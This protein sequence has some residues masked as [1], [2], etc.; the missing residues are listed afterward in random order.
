M[1][2]LLLLSY[3]ILAFIC[4]H[5]LIAQD[6][7]SSEHIRSLSKGQV[8][9]QLFNVL[10]VNHGVE[11]YKLTYTTPDIHGVQDTASGLL[12]L[13]N[14][15]GQFPL[16][17]NQHG[18]VGNKAQVP[19]NENGGHLLAVVT[20]AMSYVTVMPDY[21]GLGDAR[22]F[23]P[24]L[25]AKTEASASID[26]MRATK[27]FLE[28]MED[29][30]I[31]EQVFITGYSQGGHAALALH[32]EL[33]LHHS[34]E[35]VVTA[36]A[37]MSGPYDMSGTMIDFGFAE[38]EYFFPGYFPYTILSYQL[39][40]GNLFNEFEDYFKQPYATEIERF[41]THQIDLSE[42]NEFCIDQLIME[43]GASIPIRML[44]DSVLENFQNHSGHP[45]RVAFKDNDLHDWAPASPTRLYYCQADD[46]VPFF[47]SVAAD[48]IMNVNGASDLEA[49]DVGSN[50]DHGQCVLPAMNSTLFFFSNFQDFMTNT[51]EYFNENAPI[52][53]FPNPTSDKVVI[54]YPSEKSET[55]N[56][57]I[58]NANGQKVIQTQILSGET[59]A[60][61]VQ[62]LPT[63]IYFVRAFTS[64]GIWSK[65]LM[66][67]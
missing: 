23:H 34:D 55:F 31:N 43:H 64:E 54:Y 39:A 14:V 30:S 11:L 36:S 4:P 9:A 16:L 20:G 65:K 52:Q 17:C 5:S 3:L 41:F 59:N 26:M 63:G 25:H 45:I 67:I 24:Y 50:L 51:N 38:I 58:R 6:L 62:N 40:Y 47:N 66:I 48:S 42:L 37:P 61:D 44:Q 13:P 56:V 29:I 57:E 46:Q 1:K 22:G 18:T 33:E 7:V 10:T 12:V 28:S 53:L 8:E 49:F 2:K 60:I 15:G 21:L 27:Q 32:K 19:S 35:F